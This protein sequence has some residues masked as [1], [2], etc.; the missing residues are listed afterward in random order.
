M[1]HLLDV[2]CSIF[3]N[4]VIGPNLKIIMVALDIFSNIISNMLCTDINKSN[5]DRKM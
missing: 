1:G 2:F 3:T 4:F 5:L